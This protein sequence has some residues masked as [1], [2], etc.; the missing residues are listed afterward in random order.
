[1][2][3]SDFL[4]FHL[5]SFFW[6]GS[7][8]GYISF[9]PIHLLFSYNVSFIS[10]WLW[11]FLRLSEFLKSVSILRKC[12]SG[13]FVQCPSI[14]ICLCLSH[15]YPGLCA[16]GRKTTE[17][18]C[19]FYHIRAKVHSIKMIYD[20]WCWPWCIKFPLKFLSLFQSHSLERSY[21]AQHTFKG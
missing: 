19:H 14:R 10:C 1:M 2:L 9:R 21:C 16:S 3:Y 17:V 4:S 18:K 5:L 11:Q 8:S 13:I 15:E 12:W 6:P 7:Y 20:G